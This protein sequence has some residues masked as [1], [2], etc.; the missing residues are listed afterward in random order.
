MDF[1][2]AWKALLFTAAIALA[3]VGACEHGL[4]S[5]HAA[6]VLFDGTDVLFSNVA[7]DVA[8]IMKIIEGGV[9]NIVVVRLGF[10]GFGLIGGPFASVGLGSFP[11]ALEFDERGCLRYRRAP[12]D[13]ERCA[14]AVNLFLDRRW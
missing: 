10:I 12:H 11:V 5:V 13:T 6:L 9:I 3:M 8:V 1:Q 14:L 4:P 7:T 2:E